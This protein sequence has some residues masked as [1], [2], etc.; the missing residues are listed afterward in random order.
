MGYA[1]QFVWSGPGRG[2][3]RLPQLEEIRPPPEPRLLC[4]A[5]GALH[6]DQLAALRA[7]VRHAEIA[8]EGDEAA[9]S[10]TAARGA[11]RGR[12]GFDRRDT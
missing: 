9:L 10:L 6:P 7:G 12:I 11:D 2:E 4:S 1:G 3:W 5:L 8:V